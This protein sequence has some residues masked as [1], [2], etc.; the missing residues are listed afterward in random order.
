MSPGSK[1][2]IVLDSVDS[3]NN[4]AMAMVKKGVASHGN[5]VFA[6]EQTKGKGRRGKQWNTSVGENITMSIVAEMQWLPVLQQFELSAAVALGCYDFF[7]KHTLEVVRIKWPNDIFINDS[8]AGGILIENLIQGALW[9]WSVIGLG[10]NVNQVQ[11]ETY[12]LPPISLKQITGKDY[13]VLKMAEELCKL[14]LKRID[15]LKKNNFSKM[16]EE[17]NEKL[18]AK[19]QLVT[20]KKQNMVFQTA[21]TGVSDAGHLITQDA[22]ERRFNFDEVEFKGIV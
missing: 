4:Y 2:I 15:D 22:L 8:K 12:R 21:I 16:L 13:D 10:M 18:Y 17:Y 7:S 19:G 3:T 6:L 20:L 11:F 14:V 9:Q 5:A 1:K